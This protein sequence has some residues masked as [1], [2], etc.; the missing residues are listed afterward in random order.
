VSSKHRPRPRDFRCRYLSPS[1]SHSETAPPSYPSPPG[2]PPTRRASDRC[3]WPKAH[4]SSTVPSCA[5]TMSRSP[6]ACARTCRTTASSTSTR[7]SPSPSARACRS[8]HRRDHPRGHDRQP[9]AGRDGHHCDEQRRDRR[10]G[11]H[12]RLSADHRG[13]GGAAAAARRRRASEG[14]PRA[15]RRGDRATTHEHCDLRAARGTAAR[16]HRR[17]LTISVRGV[18]GPRRG[19]DRPRSRGTPREHTECDMAVPSRAPTSASRWAG[20]GTWRCS[21]DSERT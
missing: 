9:C 5:P 17:R 11:A 7:A 6:S 13:H 3:T 20:L 10:R 1:C 21:P 19:R 4:R 14:T 15:H 2:L 8:G 18:V 12:R 16:W